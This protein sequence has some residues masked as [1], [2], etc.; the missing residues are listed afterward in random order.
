MSTVDFSDLFGERLTITG[1]P[2]GSEVT[3]IN[4]DEMGLEDMAQFIA[5][6]RAIDKKAR[7][8]ETANNEDASMKLA[9]EMDESLNAC[10]A[11]IAVGEVDAAALRLGQKAAIL[12]RW[13]EYQEALSPN[14][15]GRHQP[16]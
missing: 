1:L 3:L 8:L 9:R 6:Q 16:S 10:L 2:D 5:M 12:R 11:R 7:L 15:R 14:G 4:R 13:N